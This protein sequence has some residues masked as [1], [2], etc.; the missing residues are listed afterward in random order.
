VEIRWA[1][2]CESYQW[3]DN[4]TVNLFGAGFDT[5]YVDE[6]PADLG[7]IVV[8]HL[9]LDEDEAGTIEVEACGPDTASLGVASYPTRAEP[10]PRHR[11]GFRISQLEAIRIADI[12]AELPGVYSVDIFL[13]GERERTPPLRR[14]TIDFNVIEGLPTEAD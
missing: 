3:R 11:P 12:P 6:L 5:I 14:R 10:G 2:A 9:F 13:E 7:V 4:G 1:V 8:V